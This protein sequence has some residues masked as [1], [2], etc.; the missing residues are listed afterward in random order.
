VRDKCRCDEI[1]RLAS[2]H[3]PSRRSVP[4]LIVE[5]KII[6]LQQ[7]GALVDPNSFI[8]VFLIKVCGVETG[9]TSSSNRSSKRKGRPSQQRITRCSDKWGSATVRASREPDFIFGFKQDGARSTRGLAKQCCILQITLEPFE[10]A[11][12]I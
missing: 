12:P 1:L 9:T 8:W 3:D 4:V 11:Y 10:P 7:G 6:G 2:F 5:E